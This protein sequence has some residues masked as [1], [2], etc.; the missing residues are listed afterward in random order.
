MFRWLF[1]GRRHGRGAI[2]PFGILLLLNSL[3]LD[4]PLVQSLTRSQCAP[5]ARRVNQ[6][7]RG[8]IHIAG[9][10]GGPLCATGRALV[11][12]GR[13]DLL[14][15]HRVVSNHLRVV[16]VLRLAESSHAPRSELR[17]LVVM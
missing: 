8:L 11:H 15:R 16:T 2:F 6:S 12:Y 4:L 10:L 1:E 17:P 3:Q 7:R 14:L 13:C 9:L 5:R